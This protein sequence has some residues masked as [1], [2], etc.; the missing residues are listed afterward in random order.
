[1]SEH[2]NPAL[3]VDGI[4]TIDGQIVL[5]ER[6]N[7][8]FKGM[9]ALPGGFVD[10][11][12]KAEDAVVREIFEETGLRTQIKQ[13]LGVYSDPDRDPRGHTVTVAFEL[14]VIGGELKSGDDAASVKLFDAHK[15]PKMAFDHDKIISDWLE[16]D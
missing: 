1:M 10:Y 2:K 12:E 14:A 4:I 7:E 15:L 9:H 8:P 5:I 16:R 13:L 3:T 11:G 6:K